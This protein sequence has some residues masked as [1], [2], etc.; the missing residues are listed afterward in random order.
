MIEHSYLI[1]APDATPKWTQGGENDDGQNMFPDHSTA[2]EKSVNSL[3]YPSIIQTISRDGNADRWVELVANDAHRIV[4]GDHDHRLSHILSCYDKF[5]VASGRATRVRAEFEKKSRALRDCTQTKEF[6]EDLIKRYEDTNFSIDFRQHIDRMKPGSEPWGVICCPVDECHGFVDFVG[7]NGTCCACNAVV[8]G[9][10]HVRIGRDDDH[11]CSIVQRESVSRIVSESKQCPLCLSPIYRVDGCTHMHCTYC[12][13]DFD[14]GTLKR[15]SKDETTNPLAMDRVGGRMRGNSNM[16]ED[17]E[18]AMRIVER[19]MQADH[20]YVLLVQ[21]IHRHGSNW[22]RSVIRGDKKKTLCTK[23][24]IVCDELCSGIPLQ[25]ELLDC[26]QG[27]DQLNHSG[28]LVYVAVVL[29]TMLCACIATELRMV[30]ELEKDLTH[31]RYKY[32]CG[33]IDQST[34]QNWLYDHNR[35]LVSMEERHTT[36]C[37][38]VREAVDSIGQALGGVSMDLEGGVHIP[39]F[40][41]TLKKSIP[42]LGW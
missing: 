20:G 33:L 35:D 30:I 19:N 42:V 41:K 40:A 8:C 27:S 34:Y 22:V 9:Q 10:C 32:M 12:H 29:L 6:Y 23:L 16:L 21:H 13:Y 1:H 38:K 11:R 15:L 5:N 37:R 7:A 3:L 25:Q 26:V 28:H 31:Q 4:S 39:R 14:W 18:A 2:G 36:S 24:D 17:I